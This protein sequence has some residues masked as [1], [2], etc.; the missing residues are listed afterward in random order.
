MEFQQ[1]GQTD[2]EPSTTF[3]WDSDSNATVEATEFGADLYLVR[4]SKTFQIK[5]QDRT[6]QETWDSNLRNL[7]EYLAERFNFQISVDYVNEAT[8]ETTGVKQEL[9]EKKR[10]GEQLLQQ[11]QRLKGEKDQFSEAAANGAGSDRFQDLVQS[12]ADAS[13]RELENTEKRLDRVIEALEREKK[14]VNQWRQNGVS[15]AY[16]FT[17]S[18]DPEITSYWSDAAERHVD[19]IVF[20]AEK[21]VRQVLE[22]ERYKLVVGELQHPR[23]FNRLEHTQLLSPE[24]FNRL[25]EE[26]PDLEDEL[27]QLRKQTAECF[28]SFALKDLKVEGQVFERS[29][30]TPAQAINGLLEDLET[31][32]IARTRSAPNNGPF[33][34]TIAGTE[35]VVG[36]DP[37]EYFNHIY[38]AGKTGSGKTY[39]KRVLLEN[40]ASLSY[41]CLSIHP[42]DTQGLS[43]SLPNPEHEDGRGLNA[44]QYW[45]DTDYVLD[46]PDSVNALLNGVNIL[47]LK[48]V[49]E[50]RK[51]ELLTEVLTAAYNA[52]YP[53]DQPLFLFIEEAQRLS[54]EAADVLKSIVKEKR[55]DNV[56]CCIVTQNPKQFKRSYASIR[57]NTDTQFLHGEYFNYAEDFDQ[58]L[59]SKREVAALDQG[60]VILQGLNLDRVLVDVRLPLSRVEKPSSEEIERIDQM[61]AAGSVDLSKP[62]SNA[63][64]SQGT[65]SEH[66]EEL[67]KWVRY[68]LSENPEKEY[69][70]ASKCHRPDMAPGRSGTA[71]DELEAMVELGV[72]E[73]KEGVERQG[74][75]TTGYRPADS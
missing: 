48:D 49:E 72:L 52:D 67:L 2:V 17:V 64:G 63:E 35:Q 10:E 8:P 9:L 36:F 28:E 11:K 24:A 73:R 12:K 58:I 21:R 56:L 15:L 68:W 18:T 39:L 3:Y 30:A 25:I 41:N 1:I 42:I 70:T 32:N 34:G 22:G 23:L 27:R 65:L 20:E 43:A 29:K 19:D 57:R 33:I 37:A 66:Q 16:T 38:I 5:K 31:E 45:P 44:D 62:G 53:D 54:N 46:W 60:Q 61:Y 26:N 4:A 50:S 14:K 71:K 6:R 74:N 59:S 75:F 40:A 7:N 69:I 47:T 55:K 51:Q 13:Q